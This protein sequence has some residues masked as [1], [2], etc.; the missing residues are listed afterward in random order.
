MR[1]LGEPQAAV[2]DA[3]ADPPRVEITVA[4]EL[5]WYRWEVGL[6]GDEQV[7]EVAKGAEVSELGGDEPEW[8]ASVGGDGKLRWREGS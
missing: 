4:W 1:S 7:R 2:Q 3:S 5:S 8:N 6:N